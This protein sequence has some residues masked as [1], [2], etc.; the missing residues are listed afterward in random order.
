MCV[1]VLCL[2]VR[3][4][5]LPVGMSRMMAPSH[6]S[7]SPGTRVAAYPKAL[8][9]IGLANIRWIRDPTSFTSSCR[10]TRCIGGSPHG[11]QTPW[12]SLNTKSHFGHACY[13]FAAPLTHEVMR[14]NWYGVAGKFLVTTFPLQCALNTFTMSSAAFH[15]S[16]QFTTSN[17]TSRAK[18]S[19]LMVCDSTGTGSAGDSST[20][21]SLASASSSFSQSS[22][23]IIMPYSFLCLTRDVWIAYGV[24]RRLHTPYKGTQT[25]ALAA[26]SPPPVFKYITLG[27]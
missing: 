10:F 27:F 26:F 6:T 20:T 22:R 3:A 15:V 9:N 24:L 2:C 5:C 11:M 21:G 4:L 16:P 19:S 1:C 23:S 17:T 13:N 12:P 18:A 14:F 8:A 25:S 7:P